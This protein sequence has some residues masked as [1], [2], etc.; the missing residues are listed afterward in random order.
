MP[1]LRKDPIVDRWIVIDSNRLL[2][3][4]DFPKENNLPLHKATCQFCPGKEHFTPSEV[5]ALRPVG[6]LLDSSGWLTRCT[7]R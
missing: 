6:S 1:E 2:G 4:V 3:P 5:D 7:L